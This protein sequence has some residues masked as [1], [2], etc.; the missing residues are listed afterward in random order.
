LFPL[1]TLNNSKE[2]PDNIAKQKQ[3]MQESAM[4]CAFERPFCIILE[5]PD[6]FLFSSA[7]KNFSKQGSANGTNLDAGFCHV[8]QL[9]RR[10]L[11]DTRY[12]CFACVTEQSS[13][14]FSAE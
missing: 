14:V 1:P 6:D 12:V 9:E 2:N 7:Y 8:E 3:E 13:T 5:K 10:R 11:P 4:P